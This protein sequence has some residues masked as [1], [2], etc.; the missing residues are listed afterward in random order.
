MKKTFFI[1]AFVVTFVLYIEYERSI[2]LYNYEKIYDLETQYNYHLKSNE[3]SIDFFIDELKQNS[4]FLKIFNEAQETQKREFLRKKIKDMLSEK[5]EYLISKGVYQLHFYDSSGTSIYRFHLPKKHGDNV[6]SKRASIAK[7]ISLKKPL[8]TYD[9][10]DYMDGFRYIYP[11]FYNGKFVGLIESSTTVDSFLNSMQNNLDS[12]YSF[13]IKKDIIDSNLPS[14]VVNQ[15]FHPTCINENYYMNNTVHNDKIISRSMAKHIREDLD[16]LIKERKSFSY[17]YYDGLTPH[18]LAFLPVYDVNNNKSA[19]LISNRVDYKP[20]YTAIEQFIKWIIFIV[21]LLIIYRLYRSNRSTT[22]LLQQ[23]KEVAD[24]TNLVSKTDANG[25]IIYVNE[26]FVRISGYSREEL[27]GKPHNIVRDSSM[28][29]SVFKQMWNTIQRGEKWHGKITNKAKDG[30][31]YTVDAT[32]FPIFDEKRNIKEYIAI[33]Y[34]ISELERLKKIL[35]QQLDSSNKTVEEKI[36]LV[37][38]Y[39][40][41]IDEFALLARTDLK[42]RITYVNDTYSDVTGFSKDEL[43]GDNHKK[44][45]VSSVRS[46]FYKEL[47]D[48]IESKKIWKGTIKNFSLNN[49]ILY[50]DTTIVPILDTKNNIIEY[51]SVQYNVTDI[52]NFQ[53]EIA[54]TQREV[55]LTMGAIGEAR[56]KETGNHV[57]RVA[58]YSQLLAIKCGMSFKEAE[59]LKEASPMHDIGK[60]GIPDAILNKPAKLDAQEWQ[61]MQTHA[62]LGYEMLK[63]SDREILKAASIVA[64]THHEK[65]DGTGYPKKLSGEDIHIYGR[66]TAVADVFDALGSERVYKKAW[67]L[68]DILNLLKQERAK[69][70]DPKVVD[71]FLENI[72]EFLEIR[73]KYKDI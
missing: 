10:G 47:W 37:E 34:D 69:H 39:E 31:K 44:M 11:L 12:K 13:M 26:A 32:I 18:L 43:M 35:E 24:E 36:Y 55:I 45:R 46:S 66:I 58:E 53:K 48:T 8:I 33:R 22:Y 63:H 23:Y 64:M 3:K 60:V 65:Y 17:E 71:T 70:F 54:D 2:Q 21:S 16:Q 42:G 67:E 27:V 4:N 68:D 6:A 1:I 56:S 38:Q 72:N 30:H 40:D 62:E 49:E 50:L 15:Q 14:K 59:L 9:I 41:A 61:V 52:F 19:Y 28:S 57:K 7:A 29:S 20:I 73:D 5:Y 51:M 25:K